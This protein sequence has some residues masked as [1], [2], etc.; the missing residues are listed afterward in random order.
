MGDGRILVEYGNLTYPFCGAAREMKLCDLDTPAVVI[1]VDVMERNL[2]RMAEYCADHQMKL[3]PHTKTHK[4]PE[5]ARHQ[6]ALGATGITVAKLGEA[7]VMADAGLDDILI[8][9][10][11]VGELKLHRLIALARR[12]R[13]TVATDSLQSAREISSCAA[14]AG[15]RIGVLAEFNT[16]FRRCGL[17]VCESSMVEARRIHDLPGLEWRGILVYPGQIMANAG[18]RPEL[19]AAENRVMAKLMAL[20]ESAGLECP[21][22]SGGNTPTAYASHEFTGIT[23]IRPGTYIFNDKNTVS[24]EAASWADCA[25]RVLTTVVSRSVAGRAIIDAGSKTLAADR[26]ESGDGIGYGYVSEYPDI[27]IEEL[28]EEHGHLDISRAALAP[29]LGERL[30]VIPNHICPV[31]NLHDIVYGIQGEEVVCEWRVAARGKVK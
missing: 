8:A 19:I 22:V 20:L 14:A 5:L 13:I 18:T 6:V 3:R 28:S 15:A 31:L 2:R 17:P 10:P 9:Y 11:I 7:E 4:I 27:L 12:A 16:G 23:E 25:A 26:L 21:M 30:R 24:A 29:R 1:D